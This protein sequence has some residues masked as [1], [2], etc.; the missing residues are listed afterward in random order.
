M[1]AAVLACI[2]PP[3]G[4]VAQAPGEMPAQGD[5]AQGDEAAAD[6]GGEDG[7]D[8]LRVTGKTYGGKA[9]AAYVVR[10]RTALR[11][12]AAKAVAKTGDAFQDWINGS[13]ALGD[14]AGRRRP[15]ENRGVTISGFSATAVL[16]NVTGGERRSWTA[17]NSTLV[18][19]D[20]DFDKLTGWPGL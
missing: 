10:K 2:G 3:T 7:S 13:S 18:A 20:V 14:W 5:P 11:R 1:V 6:T 9:S 16:G 19:L 15:L 12:Q 4:A 17:A 8:G